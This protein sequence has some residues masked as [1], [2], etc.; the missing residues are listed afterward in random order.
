MALVQFKFFHLFIIL[1]YSSLNILYY[2]Y[3]SIFFI[4]FYLSNKMNFIFIR[5]LFT[6]KRKR[7]GERSEI[8]TA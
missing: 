7:L 8:H 6:I 3:I 4:M 2:L 5:T 1:N